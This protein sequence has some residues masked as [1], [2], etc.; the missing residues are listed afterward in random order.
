V[1]AGLVQAG[2]PP[3][4]LHAPR[5]G[6]PRRPLPETRSFM[7]IGVSLTL[8]TIGFYLLARYELAHMTATLLERLQSL[9]AAATTPA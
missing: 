3:L 9:A 6:D 1:A 8:F 7:W 5:T 4:L 2:K